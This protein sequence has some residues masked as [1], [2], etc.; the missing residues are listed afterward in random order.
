MKCCGEL[1]Y[2]LDNEIKITKID[3]KKLNRLK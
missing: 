3:E 1:L 2:M